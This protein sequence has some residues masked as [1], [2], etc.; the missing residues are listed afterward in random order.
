MYFK[1]KIYGEGRGILKDIATYDKRLPFAD[2]SR[3]HVL[4]LQDQRQVPDRT[5]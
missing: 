3:A 4:G 1:A 2:V 5:I